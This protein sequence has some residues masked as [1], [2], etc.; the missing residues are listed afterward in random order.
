MTPGWP[1]S[2]IAVAVVGVGAVT[3]LVMV[4]LVILPLVRA[5]VTAVI[6]MWGRRSMRGRHA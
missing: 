4:L 2:A 5:G 1:I 6:A 3:L